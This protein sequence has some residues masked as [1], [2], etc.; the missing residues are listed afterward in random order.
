MKVLRLMLVQRRPAKKPGV[1]DVL[2][3]SRFVAHAS[4]RK[5]DM[6][7]ATAEPESFTFANSASSA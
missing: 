5:R 4:E 6:V 3:T 2:C 1:K 7:S